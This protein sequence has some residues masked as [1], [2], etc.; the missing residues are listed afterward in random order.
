MAVRAAAARTKRDLDRVRS[1]GFA[2]ENVPFF[3]HG[4]AII[5]KLSLVV[6]AALGLLANSLTTPASAQ[7]FYFGTQAGNSGYGS[8]DGP[9]R[10]ARFWTPNAVAV[11]AGGNV[12]VADTRNSTI[13]KISPEGTV[14]TLA[15]LAGVSGNTDG[16]TNTAR[17]NSPGGVAVDSVGS[18]Y[19]A[20]TYNHTIR[21]IT[22]DGTVSTLAGQAGVAGS[23]N[24]R[25]GAARFNFPGH[26]AVDS[27]GFIYVADTQNHS[28]RKIDSEGLVTTLAGSAA[29]PGAADGVGIGAQFNGPKGVA[30][31]LGGTVFVADTGNNLIRMITPGGV[32]SLLAGSAGNSGSD[33]GAGGAATF[34]GPSGVAVDG[35]GTVFVADYYNNTIRAV[36]PDGTVTTPAGVAQGRGSTDGVGNGARF[37]NPIGVAFGGGFIYVADSGNNTVRKMDS[38]NGVSTLA[39][40]AGGA[41]T[42]D[43]VRSAARFNAAQGVAA[44]RAGVIY[45]ADTFNHTIRKIT[46]DG[47]VSTLAGFSGHPGSAN[48][49]RTTARFKNPYGVAVDGAGY[50]YVADTFNYTIRKIGLDGVVTTVAGAAGI[51]GS[52]EGSPASARFYAPYAL[53]LDAAGNIF[54]ADAGN[55]SIRK[56]ATDG[57]TS[58]LAGL[59]GSPGSTDNTRS[60]ARFR[61]PT[62][63]AVGLDGNVL[64]ADT[65][66]QLIRMVTPDGVV[67]TIAGTAGVVGSLDG[68]PSQARFNSPTGVAVDSAG[69]IF[70]A[71]SGN[72]S[73]RW[74]SPG[75][76]VSTVGGVSGGGGSVDGFGGAARF[77]GLN[78]LS[79]DGAGNLYV[80]DS[81]NNTI[82]M[83]VGPLP[84]L[85]ADRAGTVPVVTLFGQPGLHYRIEWRPAVD[86]GSWLELT[87]ATLAVSVT[88]PRGSVSLVDPYGASTRFY[89]GIVLP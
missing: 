26:L 11:D 17:F 68:D 50:V 66:N 75:G 8:A 34:N 19:V 25:G 31:T 39:G 73:I 32:V 15:G 45:V 1:E 63:L 49:S 71:D 83:G 74:I 59:A 88:D 46:A 67:S 4:G 37:G 29:N 77:L 52:A 10:S 58:T 86:T 70:V 41:G 33:D 56:I 48:G 18:V 43:G 35:S 89:R 65:G 64:V 53:A 24:G 27:S 23:A 69:N 82:R 57:T 16:T 55:D 30:V 22:P 21:V 78:S 47:V 54:V 61:N 72:N 79:F 12:Y 6:C 76:Q 87:N 28:I 2:I 3:E 20:D 51:P 40:L 60:L 44:D 36:A 13:R 38:G 7:S 85:R 5:Q 42:A 14:G 84:R 81:R 9:A 62:G 80:A